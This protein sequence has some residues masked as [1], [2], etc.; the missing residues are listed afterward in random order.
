V[1]QFRPRW[2]LG[3]RYDRLDSGDV[4][5]GLVLFNTGG[6]TAADFPALAP[7][8]PDRF[9]A[10]VDYSFSEFSRLRLQYARDESRLNAGDDQFFVQYIMSLGAHGAHKW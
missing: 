8:D 5:N 9:S 1:Y 6:L 3:L 4:T 10:M 2:R 7:H